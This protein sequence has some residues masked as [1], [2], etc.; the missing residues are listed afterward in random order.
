MTT[1][2][3]PAQPPVQVA[4]RFRLLWRVGDNTCFISG[5][6]LLIA[7]PDGVLYHQVVGVDLERLLPELGSP[8]VDIE[9]VQEPDPVPAPRSGTSSSARPAE[10][11]ESPAQVPVPDA[12]PALE[13][14]EPP[15]SGWE[16]Q[17]AWGPGPGADW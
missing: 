5:D 13:L 1:L 9:H 10:T 14:I 16:I 17:A 2:T 3:A 12:E 15:R 4:K 11:P 6:T 8:Q 7:G